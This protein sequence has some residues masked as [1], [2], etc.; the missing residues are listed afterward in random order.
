MSREEFDA[1]PEIPHAEWWDGALVVSGTTQRHG[2][3]VS[4]LSMA[5]IIAAEGRGLDVLS[6]SGW[7]VPDAEFAPDLAVVPH[8]PPGDADELMTT[9]PL[10]LVEVL[11]RSTR[12]IDLGRKRELYA[13][14]GVRWYWVVD[15]HLMQLIEF[16]NIDGGFVETNRFTRGATREPLSITLDVPGL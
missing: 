13:A 3:A 14:G 1:L 8:V 12:H 10:L 2:R 6:G 9:P 16:H 15:L 7:R 11:S 5:L 4:R